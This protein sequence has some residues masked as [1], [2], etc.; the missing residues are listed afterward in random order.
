MDM[1]N[2][3]GMIR[4]RN[5]YFTLHTC[6]ICGKSYGNTIDLFQDDK[7][8][9]KQVMRIVTD[10]TPVEEAKNPES[11]NIFKIYS[12]FLDAAGR[13]DG[14]H[15]KLDIQRP[16]FLELDLAVLGLPAL[17]D[18]QVRHDLDA[19]GDQAAA[20]LKEANFPIWD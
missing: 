9:R 6:Q 7:A 10:P 3:I 12:L 5:K 20:S 17:R 1:S 2:S 16:E 8:L 18:V 15:P 19:A 14:G 13:G 11:C 4:L